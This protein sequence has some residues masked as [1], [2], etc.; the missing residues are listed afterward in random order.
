A[1]ELSSTAVATGAT[2]ALTGSVTIGMAEA[3]DGVIGLGVGPG[4]EFVGEPVAGIGDVVS[5]PDGYSVLLPATVEAGTVVRI[6]AR[7]RVS[8]VPGEVVS[9]HVVPTL[10]NGAGPLGTPVA[11]AVVVADDANGLVERGVDLG[12]A[13][14]IGI[15][16]GTL[17]RASG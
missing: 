16:A 5:T 10:A 15:T 6:A 7:A 8:A 11:R 17:S 14:G 12:D 9:A 2:V 1:L 4:L 3:R 13:W